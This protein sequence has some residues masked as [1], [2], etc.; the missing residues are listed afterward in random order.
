MNAVR[1]GLIVT[2]I[3]AASGQPDRVE[4]LKDQVPMGRAGEPEEVAEVILWL[5]SEKASYVTATLVDVA[6]GR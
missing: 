3:H 2:D 4:R 6:A 1:P 5:L